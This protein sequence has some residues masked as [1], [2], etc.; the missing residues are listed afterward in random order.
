MVDI[1]SKGV[2][3]TFDIDLSK[4][5]QQLCGQPFMRQNYTG[6]CSL[7]LSCEGPF[8]HIKGSPGDNSQTLGWG[9]AL[10]E[11]YLKGSENNVYS[12]PINTLTV[13]A[14]QNS[15]ATNS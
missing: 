4:K 5:W 2:G 12:C 15:K 9:T 3:V 11:V 10:V 8:K 7:F 13:L 6:A 14:R 1:I